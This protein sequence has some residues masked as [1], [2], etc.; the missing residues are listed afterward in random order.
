MSGTGSG[1]TAVLEQ[2]EE[3]GRR[4]GGGGGIVGGVGGRERKKRRRRRKWTEADSC[5]TQDVVGIWC[6]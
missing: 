6:Q 2:L 4:S 1:A 5:Y 3:E